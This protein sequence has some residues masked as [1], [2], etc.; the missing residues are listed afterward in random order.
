MCRRE[1]TSIIDDGAT[2]DLREDC[3]IEGIKHAHY[4]RVPIDGCCR[5]ADDPVWA[6]GDN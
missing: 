6:L 1:N 4:G 5:P 3:A 2:A